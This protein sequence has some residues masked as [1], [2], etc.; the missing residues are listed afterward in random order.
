MAHAA[1]IASLL[2][3]AT[4]LV[5]A[6]LIIHEMGHWVAL[7]RYGVPVREYWLGLGPLIF[8]LKRFRVGMLP[9]GGA[10]VPEPEAYAKLGPKQKLIVALAG[11]FASLLYGVVFLGAALV[12]QTI[13]SG[14]VLFMI[15]NLSF[16]LAAINLLPI[17][18]LDGF[19]AWASWRE[20][21]NVPLSSKTLA[22]AHRI[23]S[24]LVYG[25]GFLALGFV[26]IR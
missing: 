22:A 25:V 1:L 12:N 18:P 3:L 2:F 17:P 9:I 15:S 11:P 24:G 13:V 14:E 21:R 7:H 4:F 10:L 6:P 19:Q 23:G 26:V 20:L 5:L 8:K 16:A